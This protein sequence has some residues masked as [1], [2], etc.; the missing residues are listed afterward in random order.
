MFFVSLCVLLNQKRT[1]PHECHH[2]SVRATAGLRLVAAL[3][4]PATARG[5]LRSASQMCRRRLAR[6]SPDLF[7]YFA[8][9]IR[10]L[11]LVLLAL[12]LLLSVSGEC[13][14]QTHTVSDLSCLSTKT[15]LILRY[16]SSLIRFHARTLFAA[17]PEST[18]SKKKVKTKKA[19]AEVTELK[20]RIET[21]S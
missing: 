2:Q 7:A 3:S 8:K 20:A 19:T 9:M 12:V 13:S 17:D 21:D 4:V 5:C 16:S 15:Q 11:F 14:R 1:T 6:G 18:P 10:R